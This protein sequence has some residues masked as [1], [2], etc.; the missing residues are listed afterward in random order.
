VLLLTVVNVAAQDTL[1]DSENGMIYGGYKTLN[2]NEIAYCFLSLNA[3]DEVPFSNGMYPAPELLNGILLRHSFGHFSA[4]FNASFWKRSYFK[5]NPLHCPNCSYTSGQSETSDYQL[6]GGL[7]YTPFRRKELLYCFADLSYRRRAGTATIETVFNGADGI[8]KYIYNI[9][10]INIDVGIGTKLNIGRRFCFS[11][12]LQG[13]KF[14][15]EEY[16]RITDIKTGNEM[17][18]NYPFNL[19]TCA[20]RSYFSILF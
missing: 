7:Q 4:R 1:S 17:R 14:I 11:L 13:Y 19:G 10:G 2:R 5:D 6:G 9:N 18:G 20:L 16:R 3:I 15:A 12:E 8:E